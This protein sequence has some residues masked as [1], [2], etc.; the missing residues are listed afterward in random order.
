MLRAGSESWLQKLVPGSSRDLQQ[1][2]GGAER[3]D[4]IGQA[5]LVMV[6]V[7]LVWI[8]QWA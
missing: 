5:G 4:R 3:M 6:V 8:R 7:V 2:I 1:P